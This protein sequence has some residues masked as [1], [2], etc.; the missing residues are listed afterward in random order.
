MRHPVIFQDIIGIYGK[1]RLNQIDCSRN[2]QQ[3]ISR[4]KS[5]SQI[6]FAMK[7]GAQ[8]IHLCSTY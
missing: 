4:I 5:V 7:L 3:F 6:F 2:I 8:E 1:D